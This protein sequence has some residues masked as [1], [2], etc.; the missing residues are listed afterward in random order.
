[1]NYW[2]L[3]AISL[4][5]LGLVSCG[6]GSALEAAYQPPTIV[7]AS[8]QDNTP[9]SQ[10]NAPAEP[11]TGGQQS[12]N[13]GLLVAV[14]VGLLWRVTQETVA[15]SYRIQASSLKTAVAADMLAV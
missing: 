6:G 15:F 11:E 5:S 12:N 4:G 2:R 3:L 1:M 9:A 7:N 14:A 13:G 10:N 8:Q